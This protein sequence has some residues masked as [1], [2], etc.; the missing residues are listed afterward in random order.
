LLF[1]NTFEARTFLAAGR[2]GLVTLIAVP[3]VDTPARTLLL[4]EPQLGVG[5]ADF[6]IAACEQENPGQRAA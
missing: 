1:K 4:I 3:V 6:G 5:L 2:V